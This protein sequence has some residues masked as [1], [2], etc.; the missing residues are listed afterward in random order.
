MDSVETCIDLCQALMRQVTNC[1]TIDR[2][3]DHTCTY[4]TF[5]P[6]RK[7]HP[8]RA[9]YTVLT[10]N[11]HP[12]QLIHT[13]GRDF[14]T[15]VGH[16]TCLQSSCRRKAQMTASLALPFRNAVQYYP[17]CSTV[18]NDHDICEPFARLHS[19]VHAHGHPVYRRKRRTC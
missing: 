5:L 2:P 8:A 1:T 6:L 4:S 3:S 9:I 7:L 10:R 16:V 12:R 18:C 11:L 19:N 14:P 17:F 13:N 15:K